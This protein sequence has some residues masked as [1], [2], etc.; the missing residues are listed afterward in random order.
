M[1]FEALELPDA[2]LI[3]LEPNFDS[4]GLFARTWCADEFE[5]AGLPAE[6][7]QTNLSQTLRRGAI[8]GLHYQ[9]PPSREGKVVRCLKGGIF[10]VIVDIRPDSPTFLRHVGVELT[11][12]NRSA[13]YIPPGLAHGF[14]TL[15]PETEIWYQMTDRYQPGLSGGLRWDDPALGIEWP[16]KPTS[17][18]ERDATYPDL[19]RGQLE[20]FRGVR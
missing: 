13:L 1:K 12:L 9:R 4:R 14:Q 19:D 5:S 11:P 10:D 6:I 2:F 20:C 3:E 17:M 8:R 7:L 15:E 16:L 18:N